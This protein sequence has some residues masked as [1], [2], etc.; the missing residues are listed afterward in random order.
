MEQTYNAAE[1]TCPPSLLKQ[2]R[3]K[4]LP[5]TRITLSARHLTSAL[6]L[7]ENRLLASSRAAPWA[8]GSSSAGRK[9]VGGDQRVAYLFFT[10]ALI[11]NNNTVGAMHVGLKVAWQSDEW[12]GRIWD[13]GQQQQVARQRRGDSNFRFG[14]PWPGAGCQRQRALQ[15]SASTAESNAR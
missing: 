8:R 1:G 15:S 6:S 9:S 4:G 11:T 5:M 10:V 12:S 14:S 2:P 3:P 13:Q 7:G